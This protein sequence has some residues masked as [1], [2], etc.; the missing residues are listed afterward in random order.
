MEQGELGAWEAYGGRVENL[1][2][3]MSW[4]LNGNI[5]KIVGLL[6]RFSHLPFILRL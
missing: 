6:Q 3:V 4:L 1:V 5:Y 2:M